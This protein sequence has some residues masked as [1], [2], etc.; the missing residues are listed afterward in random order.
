MV[1]PLG[2]DFVL[3]LPNFIIIIYCFFSLSLVT[4]LWLYLLNFQHFGGNID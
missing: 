2:L 1:Y 3:K 4:E